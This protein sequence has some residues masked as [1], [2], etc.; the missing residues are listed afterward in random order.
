VLKLAANFVVN[1]FPGSWNGST[2]YSDM[3]TANAFY[4]ERHFISAAVLLCRRDGG[5]GHAKPEQGS[6][7]KPYCVAPSPQPRF[8]EMAHALRS[9]EPRKT[10]QRGLPLALA[11]QMLPQGQRKIEAQDSRK[12]A[13]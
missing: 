5:V 6:R 9:E 11:R 8:N 13:V 2:T 10:A 1:L 12:L 7:A 4:D 3:T